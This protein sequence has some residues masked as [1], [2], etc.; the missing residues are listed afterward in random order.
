MQGS[1]VWDTEMPRLHTAVRVYR[2][3]DNWTF[4]QVVAKYA[5]LGVG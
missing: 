5:M 4:G 3:D 2:L 1:S